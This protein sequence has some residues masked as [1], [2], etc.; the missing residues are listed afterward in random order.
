VEQT[1]ETGKEVD[2]DSYGTFVENDWDTWETGFL[3]IGSK[4]EEYISD[5]SD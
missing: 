4:R 1:S 3:Y 5:D 2:E